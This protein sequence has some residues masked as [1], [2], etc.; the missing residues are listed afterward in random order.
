[1]DPLT[2]PG[3][4]DSLSEI[5]QY[6]NAAAQAAGLDKKV[7][8]RLRLAVDEV[9]TNSVI[10]GYE[11]SGTT[12]DLVVRSEM[13]SEKLT[14]IVEDSAPPFD[15]RSLQER[16]DHID[17]PVE[18]RPIGGLGVYLTVKNVDKFDYEYVNNRNRNIFVV[19][20]PRS[21]GASPS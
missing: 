5:G 1:M 19:N 8:Y 6:V 16:P 15:L 11:E 14:I 3:V 2:L 21:D 18:D 4:L 7:A 13:D 17:K 10:H 9:A 20:R 12:G